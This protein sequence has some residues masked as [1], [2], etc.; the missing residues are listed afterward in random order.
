V[1]NKGDDDEGDD[2]DKGDDDDDKGDDDKDDDKGDGLG[3][4][5]NVVGMEI[6]SRIVVR[7]PIDRANTVR[8]SRVP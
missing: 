1:N 3:D 2:D 6:D 8:T 4:E 5:G 7:P